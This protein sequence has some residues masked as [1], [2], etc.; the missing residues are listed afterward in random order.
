MQLRERDVL[1][2][3]LD[4]IE[5]G[6]L[7]TKTGR[8]FLDGVRQCCIELLSMKNIASFE[9]DELHTLTGMLAEMNCIDE[10]SQDIVG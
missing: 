4:E 10:I 8:I 3:R 1:A 9:I 6:T 5:S 2:E 7:C